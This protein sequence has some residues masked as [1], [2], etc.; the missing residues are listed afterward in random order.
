MQRRSWEVYAE[1]AP[2]EYELSLV[3]EVDGR[4]VQIFDKDGPWIKIVGQQYPNHDQLDRA[5]FEALSSGSDDAGDLD[6]VAYSNDQRRLKGALAKLRRNTLSRSS[7]IRRCI[8][9]LK[10][11]DAGTYRAAI[12]R[13]FG[14]LGLAA[15][16]S[17]MSAMADLLG[18][19]NAELTKFAALKG[20]PLASGDFRLWPSDDSLAGRRD[21]DPIRSDALTFFLHVARLMDPDGQASDFIDKIADD[22]TEDELLSSYAKLLRI[23]LTTEVP[24][25]LQHLND[26]FD[27]PET[28][29]ARGEAVQLLEHSGL[30]L[31][32]VL[33]L[34]STGSLFARCASTIWLFAFASRIVVRRPFQ[35]AGKCHG[36]VIA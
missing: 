18:T 6:D 3:A 32:V 19:Q 36:G 11:R 35:S 29:R 21:G 5:L 34:P 27:L 22:P 23:T 28:R 13:I 16:V 25:E 4:E 15:T 33:Q 8:E 24:E 17:D 10:S 31:D 20:L 7:T 14:S 26:E 9:M 30:V 2:A 12:G 1:Y